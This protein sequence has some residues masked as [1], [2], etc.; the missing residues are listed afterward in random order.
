[1]LSRRGGLLLIGILSVVVYLIRLGGP[2]DLES[3]AQVLNVGYLLDLM[4]QGHWIVQHDLENA[5]I[6]K[7][8]PGL[9]L[10]HAGH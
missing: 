3:Y 6:S 7:P 2:T 8:P 1:M 4:N 10:A 9:V 5:V